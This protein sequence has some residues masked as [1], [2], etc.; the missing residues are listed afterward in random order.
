MRR[1]RIGCLLGVVFGLACTVAAWADG[2]F[3][4]RVTSETLSEMD[5]GAQ[6]AFLLRSKDAQT[7]YIQSSVTGKID[8]F[9]WVLPLPA[10][11]TSVSKAPKDLFRLLNDLT[12]PRVVNECYHSSGSHSS[13][14]CLG[15]SSSSSMSTPGTPEDSQKADTDLVQVLSAGEVGSFAYEVIASESSSDL[16]SWL[17]T[18]RYQVPA[19][20]E[21]L[22]ADYVAQGYVFLV[23]KVART[24]DPAV[25]LNSLPALAIGFPVNAPL[26]YPMRFTAYSAGA[27]VPVLLYVAQK[28]AIPALS[29]GGGYAESHI[30]EWLAANETYD[31][32]LSKALAKKAAVVLQMRYRLSDI[33]KLDAEVG[34]GQFRSATYRYGQAAL[35]YADYDPESIALLASLLN[36]PTYVWARWYA[37]LTAAE[38]NA[39]MALTSVAYEAS[40]WVD[41]VVHTEICAARKSAPAGGASLAPAPPAFSFGLAPWLLLLVAFGLRMRA[42]RHLHRA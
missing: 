37:K 39:D 42:R 5:M 6:Q 27:P 3:S 40:V 2:G 18:N 31:A 24:L 23:A 13:L 15:G 30:A 1:S 21:T 19:G 36:D 41:P 7:L 34:G 12:A 20:A 8:D 22:F 28:D 32:A 29:E 17:R 14:G 10:N 9:A 16:L 33:W 35:P 25:S 11:P 38:M 4:I 26:V